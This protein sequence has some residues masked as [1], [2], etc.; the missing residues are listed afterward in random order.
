MCVQL[1]VEDVVT[2]FKRARRRL[3]VLGYN[4]CLTT[5]VEAPRLAKNHYDQLKVSPLPPLSFFL[6]PPRL[7]LRH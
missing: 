7:N 2:D 4:S 3:L 6:S 5:A 1:N